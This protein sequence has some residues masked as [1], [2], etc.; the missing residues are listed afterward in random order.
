V[1]YHHGVG[2]GLRGR[3]AGA[4]W[5]AG[6]RR[7]PAR[8]PR[9]PAAESQEKDTRRQAQYTRDRNG[10][11]N[12]NVF[13][14]AMKLGL[15][16]SYRR[17]AR[18]RCSS[19]RQPVPTYA[20]YVGQIGNVGNLRPIGNRPARTSSVRVDHL[21]EFMHSAYA[22]K[23]RR[24]TKKPSQLPKVFPAT[25]TPGDLAFSPATPTFLSAFCSR[26][27]GCKGKLCPPIRRA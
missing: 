20:D 18:R 3:C 6:P 5:R 22:K 9:Y 2:T 7:C 8:W 21:S 4:G 1:A 13:V 16:P 24:G 23:P 27:S 19:L 12:E 11:G 17:G 26:I 10:S 25:P 15:P 14:Q